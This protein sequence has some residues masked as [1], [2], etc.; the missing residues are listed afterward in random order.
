MD[1]HDKPDLIGIVSTV[2]GRVGEEPCGH[3]SQ[4][5]GICGGVVLTRTRRTL[6]KPPR[7][8]RN[9]QICERAIRC[10]APRHG[11]RRHGRESVHGEIIHRHAESPWSHFGPFFAILNDCIIDR[12]FF[13][14]P[15]PCSFGVVLAARFIA[16][17]LLSMYA[18][19]LWLPAMCCCRRDAATVR[20]WLVTRAAS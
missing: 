15:P 11:R 20:Q 19:A 9:C 3:D 14:S 17:V 8:E 10:L 16:S 6:P 4:A 5:A 13:F 7:S 18:C 12:L 2:L 1:V